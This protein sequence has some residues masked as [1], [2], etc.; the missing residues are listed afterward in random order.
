MSHKSP[1]HKLRPPHSAPIGL[2]ITLQQAL[3]L[4]GNFYDYAQSSPHN[5]RLALIIVI[6]AG[7]SHAIGSSVIL[8][9][10][11]VS[12]LSL[13]TTSLLTGLTI[14]AG[15]YLWTFAIWKIGQWLKP[16]D[17]TYNDLLVPIGFAYA[18]QV[19]NFLTL[20]PLL[21]RPIELSLAAWSL[22]AVV[23]AIR[24]GL[25]ISTVRAVVISLLFWIPLQTAIGA[26]QVLM[27]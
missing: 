1:N 9:I 23:V 25:D 19:L 6:L 3:A 11:R 26:I 20:I 17:P 18:P 22:L 13:I 21:G 24:E 5:R 4:D 14:V 8:L 7:I 12:A 10:N 15:Y 2:R 27:Q 16:I